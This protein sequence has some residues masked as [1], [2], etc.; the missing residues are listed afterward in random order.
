M[1]TSPVTDDPPTSVQT[2]TAVCCLGHLIRQYCSADVMV[3][4]A[5]DQESFP[6]ILAVP[7]HVV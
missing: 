3:P 6:G 1:T 2:C 5:D 7:R 4:C